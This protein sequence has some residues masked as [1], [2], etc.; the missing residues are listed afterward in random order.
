MKVAVIT[1]HAISNY[2]SLLQSIATQEIVKQLGHQ[3]EIID[4]IRT[5]EEYINWEK[6]ILSAKP[7]WSSPL[8]RFVYL[9]IRQP[10]SIIAGRK[11]Q[12]MRCQNLS[13]TKRYSSLKE[14]EEG[15]FCADVYMTGSDQVWGPVANGVYDSAYF[16]SFVPTESKKIAFAASMGKM[17]ISEESLSLFRNNLPQYTN[18]AVREQTAADFLE[19]E[20]IHCK[21]VLDPTLLIQA[22]K[23]TEMASPA[24]KE[25]YVLVY[26]LHNNQKLNHFAKKIAA[27]MNLPLVR[28]SPTLHQFNRGGKF[29]YLPDVSEFLSLI[30]NASFMVTDSFHGTAFAINFNVPFAEILPENG[31]NSRNVSILNLTGLADRIVTTEQELDQLS[32]SIDFAYANQVIAYKRRESMEI[33]KG[34]LA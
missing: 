6:T 2:G 3:C 14:L 11:F 4:Y 31:T 23:W 15:V 30:R 24:R 21:T 8:K 25:K 32:D 20:G 13:L 27:R 18:I 28:V 33:L 34:F 1:R 22:E 9:A 12:K 5:D 10:E 17:K 19:S 16:L 26:Q 29:V 7:R